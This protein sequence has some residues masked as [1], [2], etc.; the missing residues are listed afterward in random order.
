MHH[1]RKCYHTN[2]TKDDFDG[3]LVNVATRQLV[4]PVKAWIESR[5]WDGAPRAEELLIRHLQAD[6]NAYVRAVTRVFLLAAIRRLWSPGCIWDNVLTLIGPQGCGKSNL[7]KFLGNDGR[8]S[9]NLSDGVDGKDPRILLAD[10]WLIEFA[11]CAMQRKST[12]EVVKS[13]ISEREDS[14]RPVYGTRTKKCKRHSV[15]IGTSNDDELL[16]DP[17][18]GRRFL[19]VHCH[20]QGPFLDAA[21]AQMVWAEVLEWY[22]RMTPAQRERCLDLPKDAQ[23]VAKQL[24]ADATAGSD[25]AGEIEAYL[26]WKR[27][28]NWI[29]T[30]VKRRVELHDE[31]V[32]GTE[33]CDQICAKEVFDVV[34]RGKGKFTPALAADI[35]G[36]VLRTGSWRELKKKN[37]IRLGDTIYGKQRW[38]IRVGSRLDKD[39]AERRL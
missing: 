3:A 14:F 10:N 36:Q 37:S 2:I 23:A 16:V 1:V 25:T 21:T 11:E 5:P 7:I 12:I 39:L 38:L 29:K 18:G 6:D 22:R 32:E 17:T 8:F 34:M 19:I 9:A 33:Q 28:E 4:H 24:Q 27:P 35:R 26:D 15:L 31:G 13:F 30:P 20:G